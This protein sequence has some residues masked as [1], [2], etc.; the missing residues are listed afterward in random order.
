MERIFGSPMSR[1][2]K[3]KLIAA[4]FIAIV[5]TAC[6]VKTIKIVGDSMSP[7]LKDGQ[8]LVLNTSAYDS[9]SPRRGDVIAFQ[10][11][12]LLISRI[13][14]LPGEA[15]HISGGAVSI[16]GAPL[17]EPYLEAGTQTTAPQTD[18]SVPSSSYFVLFDNRSHAGGDSRTFGPV[19]R[20]AIQGKVG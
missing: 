18:Y 8:V 12:N 15:L 2:G 5:M 14:G 9:A 20:S 1:V 19:P 4:L 6:G 7:T 3:Q 10:I 16:N 11:K 17:P 13:V